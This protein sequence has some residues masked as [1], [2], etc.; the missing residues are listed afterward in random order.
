MKQLMQKGLIRRW[1]AGDSGST[2]AGSGPRPPRYEIPASI[3][4]VNW[5]RRG[6]R[7]KKGGKRENKQPNKRTKA[8][9]A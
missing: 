7:K 5:W 1:Y 4:M 3:G 6:Q 2:R 8:P 9:T